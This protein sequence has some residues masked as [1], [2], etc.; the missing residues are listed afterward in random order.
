MINLLVFK[1]TTLK[2]IL[3]DVNSFKSKELKEGAN[4]F[5]VPFLGQVKF[6]SMHNE[7]CIDNDK[8]MM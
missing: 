7:Q 4:R 1:I 6:D 5:L 2:V 3:K 8:E